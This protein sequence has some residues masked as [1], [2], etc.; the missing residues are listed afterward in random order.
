MICVKQQ[1]FIA[2]KSKTRLWHE[3][4]PKIGVEQIENHG[5]LYFYLY[6]LD[7]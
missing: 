1:D 4:V 6:L 5:K 3:K 7:T 2:K